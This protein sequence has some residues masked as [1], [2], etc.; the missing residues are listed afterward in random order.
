MSTC[1]MMSES[2]R[3]QVG[4]AGGERENG[5]VVTSGATK[6]RMAKS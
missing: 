2:A 3:E 4:A 1:A 5:K 6:E